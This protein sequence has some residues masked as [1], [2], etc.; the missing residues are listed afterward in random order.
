MGQLF[1][2]YCSECGYEAEVSGGRD[3][4]M[5]AV[6]R[7]MTCKDCHDL[8]QV[9][10]GG[11]GEDGPTGDPEF[12]KDLGLCPLC[13]GKNVNSWTRKHPCPK[14]GAKMDRDDSPTV[15]WD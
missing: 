8:V 11:H 2:F 10:I 15:M 14:C 9:L 4:G 6:V 7:T 13:E 3:V 12:D 1:R 5:L